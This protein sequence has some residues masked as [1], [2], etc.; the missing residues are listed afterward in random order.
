MCK[1][2]ETKT[3]D[4]SSRSQTEW[5]S[6]SRSGSTTSAS[7]WRCTFRSHS[8]VSAPY[9]HVLYSTSTP[10]GPSLSNNEAVK[11]PAKSL[12]TSSTLS[13]TSPLHL[14]FYLTYYEHSTAANSIALCPPPYNQNTPYTSITPSNKLP[15]KVLVQ[16]QAQA[17][18]LP[19]T[20]SS[21]MGWFDGVSEHGSHHHHHSS[22]REHEHRKSSSSGKHHRHS[23]PRGSSSG[24]FGLGDPKH[25]A[26]R[27]SGIF[28]LGDPK[29]NSSRSSFFG[30]LFSFPPSYRF[31]FDFVGWEV[32]MDDGR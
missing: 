27:G 14:S 31:L 8:F 4:L 22:S 20:P 15:I 16:A 28:G 2:E 6:T 7:W 23:S 29:H 24:I 3:G 19:S 17:P 25:N 1:G 11:L 13:A 21:K 10:V 9:D 12:N 18:K 5:T 30:M 26:S 32:G